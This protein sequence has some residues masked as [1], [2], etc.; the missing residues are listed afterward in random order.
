MFSK[1]ILRQGTLLMFVLVLLCGLLYGPAAAEGE[2]S[3]PTAEHGTIQSAVDDA[4]CATITVAAGVYTGTVRIDR[5]LSIEGQ[6]AKDSILDGAA[7]GTVILIEPEGAEQAVVALRRLTVRNGR[8]GQGG[9]IDN[10][11]AALTIEDSV[12]SGNE[13]F[14]MGGGLFN[15]QQGSV[16][17]R[18][19]AVQD[20]VTDIDGGGIFNDGTMTIYSSGI[21]HNEA[22]S[23]SGGGIRNEGTLA[24]N[25]ST[26]SSN[27]DNYV[28]G[29]GISNWEGTLY[30]HNCTVSRNEG[31]PG[32]QNV[33][34]TVHMQNSLLSGNANGDCGGTLTS[35]GYTL[36]HDTSKCDLQSGPGDMLGMPAHLRQLSGEPAAHSL[37]FGPGVNG[38]DP[39]GCKD[40][41]GNLLDTDQR[42]KPRNGRCDMGAVEYLGDYQTAYLPVGAAGYAAPC[43]DFADDFSDANSG[44]YV[45]EDSVSRFSYVNGEYE[46]HSKSADYFYVS[47][48]PTCLRENYVAGVDARW[49]GRTANSYGLIFSIDPD[50]N[51]FYLFEV[52]TD[53]QVFMLIHGGPEGWNV[54]V[55][56]QENQ[57]IAKGTATNRLEVTRDGQRIVL[58]VNGTTI[59]D[60]Q[61]GRI[62]GPT[63]VGVMMSP[64]KNRAEAEARF[65]NFVV[66]SLEQ[67][68]NTAVGSQAARALPGQTAVIREALPAVNWPQ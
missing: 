64:Y 28:D 58:A 3:V 41:E 16:V 20:N 26:I 56:P 63:A 40:H 7:A 5:S 37:R 68:T 62:S 47:T 14:G 4:A 1:T 60:V 61:D 31:S 35:S 66:S 8:S 65:D 57:A 23:F 21:V 2:C 25:N 36:V 13:A 27:K 22:S 53:Y 10:R 34:G 48:A 52:N 42:D 45:G 46:I 12:L 11:G 32:V 38:G 29:S 9:G 51:A 6:T 17:L 59:A 43:L 24:I 39:A 67:E 19:T 50:T 30:L 54:L 15:D 49:N 33:G 55:E 44:W 18:R